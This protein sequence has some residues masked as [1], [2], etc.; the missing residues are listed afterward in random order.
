MMKQGKGVLGARYKSE[1]MRKS[2][3]WGVGGWKKGAKN[4]KKVK[5]KGNKM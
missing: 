5:S 4:E 2:L 3:A 1:Q